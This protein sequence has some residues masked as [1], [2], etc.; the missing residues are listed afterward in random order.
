[1]EKRPHKEEIV[2][3]KGHEI[4]GY[5]GMVFS[6]ENGQKKLWIGQVKTGDWKYCLDGIKDDINKSIIKYYFA[7]AIAILCD[8]MRPVNSASV[9]L[10]KSNIFVFSILFL[11]LQATFAA[12]NFYIGKRLQAL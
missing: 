3:R 12:R 11:R 9:E 1:M 2:E 7:D 6:I 5:D 8:I 10:S 4:K